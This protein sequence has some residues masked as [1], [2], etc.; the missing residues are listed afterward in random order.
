MF[1]L[2][3]LTVGAWLALRATG[4]P[5]RATRAARL[6]LA[7]ELAQGAVGV[8]QYATGL[9]IVLVAVHML[10]AALI[11]AAAA[12]LVLGTRERGLQPA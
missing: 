9:P 6:L 5:E 10:G 11:S 12:W 2:L 4:A 8:T 3:G 1:L 7:L